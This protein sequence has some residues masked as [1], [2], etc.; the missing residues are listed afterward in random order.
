MPDG[1]WLQEVSL[2]LIVGVPAMLAFT[3]VQFRR[4]RRR[5][6]VSGR[7][8]NGLTSGNV[9]HVSVENKITEE[10]EP[11]VE[12]ESIGERL[13]QAVCENDQLRGW[14]RDLEDNLEHVTREA[15]ELV[16]SLRDNE[17][18]WEQ[19]EAER[20]RTQTELTS[21]RAALEETVIRTLALEEALEVERGHTT[22]LTAANKKLAEQ[23][24][25]TRQTA[26]TVD[27][28]DHNWTPRRWRQQRAVRPYRQS[29]G[30]LPD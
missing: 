13:E 7:E 20:L 18:R 23:L 8:K 30:T 16:N 21:S 22:A 1:E 14:L 5:R 6:V 4:Q 12:L 24:Q 2:A 25:Q 15:T 17:L 9:D 10:T 29:H 3:L 27:L 19:A 26:P 28:R 11:A